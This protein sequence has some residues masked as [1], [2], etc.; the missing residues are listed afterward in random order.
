MEIESFSSLLL[1]YYIVF[2]LTLPKWVI[3]TGSYYGVNQPITESAYNPNKNL[4]IKHT[5]TVSRGVPK[6]YSRSLKIPLV[7]LS[8]LGQWF[9]NERA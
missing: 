9:E 4:R 3:I 6:L 2:L 7:I 5:H 1:G 8:Q